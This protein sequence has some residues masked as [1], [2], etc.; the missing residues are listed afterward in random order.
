MHTPII[1]LASQSTRLSLLL[2]FPD[3]RFTPVTAMERFL[4]LN[5]SAVRLSDR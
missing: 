5:V 2:K 4:S 3:R 1:P